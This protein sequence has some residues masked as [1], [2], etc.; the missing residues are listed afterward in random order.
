MT[1]MGAKHFA[2]TIPFADL[3]AALRDAAGR[4]AV[5]RRYDPATGL[6]LWVYTNTCIYDDL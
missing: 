6:S 2:R 3:L 4:R 5:G 1:S